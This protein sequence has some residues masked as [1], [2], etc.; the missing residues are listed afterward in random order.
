[1]TEGAEEFSDQ[2]LPSP[3]DP[4]ALALGGNWVL[5]TRFGRLDLMQWIGD[6]RLWDSLIQGAVEDEIAGLRMRVIGYEDLVRL[7][8]EA[9]RPEDALDLERLGQARE[10]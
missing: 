7:K 6:T 10:E 8:R 4:Q 3:R 5:E 1:M 2:E 9:G